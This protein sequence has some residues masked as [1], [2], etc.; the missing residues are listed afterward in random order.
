MDMRVLPLLLAL[1][2]VVAPVSAAPSGAKPSDVP[3]KVVDMGSPPGA[4]RIEVDLGERASA[5]EGE[6]GALR[7]LSTLLE[8]FPRS[9]QL[10]LVVRYRDQAK[11]VQSL[12]IEYWRSPDASRRV[13]DVQFIEL[14][15][16]GDETRNIQ[17]WGTTPAAVQKVAQAGGLVADL[18]F[19]GAADLD[20]RVTLDIGWHKD[21]AEGSAA[22]LRAM[23]RALDTPV[24]TA[25]NVKFSYDNYAKIDVE[26]HFD[27]VLEYGHVRLLY[28]NS[29]GTGPI[30]LDVTQR[31][32]VELGK[33][34]GSLDDLVGEGAIKVENPPRPLSGIWPADGVLVRYIPNST[35]PFSG[36][37]LVSVEAFL[38]F[39]GKPQQAEP[40][41]LRTMVRLMQQHPKRSDFHVVWESESVAGTQQ[42][43]R[44]VAVRGGGFSV[45]NES[46]GLISKADQSEVSRRDPWQIF[47]FAGDEPLLKTAAHNGKFKDLARWG[48]V[49]ST[50]PVKI[51]LG[52][53]SSYEDG[54]RA[55]LRT[56]ARHLKDTTVSR[57]YEIRFLHPGADRRQ[58]FV[59]VRY[60]P[61]TQNQLFLILE[62]LWGGVY[63][64]DYGRVTPKMILEVAGK[65]GSLDD[66]RKAGASYF[67]PQEQP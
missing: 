13:L 49:E 24:A 58:R 40:A 37:R 2:L 27:P 21:V 7:Q 50:N 56:L 44:A 36:G 31:M 59:E 33:R 17:L 66:L 10:Q 12:Q 38:G 42:Q 43:M 4:Q 54:C 19:H 8:R 6:R 39:R 26:I 63:G 9:R 16:G 53:R 32:I 28:P 15:D 60:S 51:F 64:P 35:Y 62:G 47:S 67:N 22:A 46:L 3:V 11:K 5:R 14:K 57:A 61:G 1:T 34:S 30:Y 65:S 29:N 25:C 18:K 23:S 45:K 55:S 41:V 52:T 48:A 20:H